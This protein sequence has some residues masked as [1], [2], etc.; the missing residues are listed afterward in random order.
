[1]L[2]PVL[3]S[4]SAHVA[5]PAVSQSPGTDYAVLAQTVAYQTD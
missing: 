5:F 4:M 1:M 3:I 2:L